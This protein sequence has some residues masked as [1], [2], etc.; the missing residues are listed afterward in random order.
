MNRQYNHPYLVTAINTQKLEPVLDSFDENWLQKFIFD[1]PAAIPINEIEPAFGRLIPLCRE[2]PTGAGPIDLLFINNDGLLTLVECKLWR[3]PEARREVVG[4]ILDYAK[5]IS[6][7]SYE[8]LEDAIGKTQQSPKKRLFDLVSQNSDVDVEERDFVDS[9]LRNL[10][11]G[12]FLLLIIGDG[13]REN[14]EQMAEFLQKYAHLNFGFALVEFGVFGIPNKKDEYLVQSRLITQTVEIE[15]AV[16]RIEDNQITSS[17]PAEDTVMPVEKRTKIT[18]QVFF[19]KLQADAPVKKSLKTFF[20]KIQNIGLYI[21]PGQNSMK[22]KSR[23]FDINF[24]VFTTK[25][26]F[27]NC[28]IASTTESLGKPQ[29]GDEYLVGL[30]KLLKNG[31]VK[32]TKS[33]FLRTVKV[34]QGRNDRYVEVAEILDVQDQWIEIIQQTLD[35]ITKIETN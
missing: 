30:S 20:E 27:Y 34:K 13:I 31:F 1:H 23:L 28:G 17:A 24:G 15:R 16:F 8:H 3:N 26:E 33:L 32:Q 10:R 19:D 4:Q 29:I 7:W 5:E 6:Q 11:R 18:E 2:L 12:R 14:V 25:G 21:E 35:E 22:L 9:V